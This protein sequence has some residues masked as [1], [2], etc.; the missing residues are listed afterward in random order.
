MVGRLFYYE[1]TMFFNADVNHP[2]LL[3]DTQAFPEWVR[4]HACD[5]FVTENGKGICCLT[6][7][8]DGSKYVYAIWVD[9]DHRGKGYGRALLE[10]AKELSPK[11]L[12]IHVNVQNPKALCLYHDCGF[13]VAGMESYNK[14]FCRYERVYMETSPGLLGKEK[15]HEEFDY[16]PK[17]QKHLQSEICKN[18]EKNAF[19][20]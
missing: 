1:R 18:F 15:D 17:S 2:L 12:S 10:H 13:K 5:A 7:N 8:K 19:G 20:V 9:R 4:N 11:G 14:D 3:N 16:P 6:P